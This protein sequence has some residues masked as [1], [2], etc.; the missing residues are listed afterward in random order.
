MYQQLNDLFIIQSINTYIHVCTHMRKKKCLIDLYAS[1]YHDCLS[2]YIKIAT[3]LFYIN[4]KLKLHMG[5]DTHKCRG[6][7]QLQ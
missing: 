7:K 5:E 4:I 2:D 6:I 1:S 3:N